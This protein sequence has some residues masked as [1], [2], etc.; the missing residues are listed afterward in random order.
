M[1]RRYFPDNPQQQPQE[2]QKAPEQPTRSTTPAPEIA[3]FL[4]CNI[5]EAFKELLS[6]SASTSASASASTATNSR[7]I[8]GN[9]RASSVSRTIGETAKEVTGK[10]STSANHFFVFCLFVFACT[11]IFILYL[12]QSTNILRVEQ[13]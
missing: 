8:S 11:C 7:A 2:Q 9:S 6:S 5:P 3:D 10:A 12:I 4:S 1:A 13:K